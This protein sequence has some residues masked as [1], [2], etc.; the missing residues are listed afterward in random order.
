MDKGNSLDD[1][2]VDEPIRTDFDE[3]EEA[4]EEESELGAAAV[5]VNSHY[6]LSSSSKAL[7]SMPDQSEGFEELVRSIPET[8]SS[9]DDSHDFMS[10]PGVSFTA[11]ATLFEDTVAPVQATSD[12][13]P[14]YV[15]N[16]FMCCLVHN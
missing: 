13:A 4:E 11:K 14:V 2:V 5:V 10:T 3:E 12:V 8:Q 9:L 6:G 1:E 7:A 15:S 16:T